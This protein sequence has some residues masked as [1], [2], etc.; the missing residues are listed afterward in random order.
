MGPMRRLL[1]LIMIVLLPLRGWAGDLMSVQMA[2][3]SAVSASVEAAM[4]PGC[5]MHSQASQAHPGQDGE[6]SPS[7][8]DMKNCASCGLCV[9]L[10]ELAHARFD[11]V[12]FAGHAQPLVGD[13]AFV[14]ASLAPT[15]KP[16]IF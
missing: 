9:P 7:Q 12:A 16:P 3:R 10:A 11:T 1:V 4:P 8:G 14:S 15:V 5:P 13:A 2:T 6:G